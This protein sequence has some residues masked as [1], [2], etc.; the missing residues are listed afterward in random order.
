MPTT[1]TGTAGHDQVKGGFDRIYGLGGDDDLTSEWDG[2]VCLD[3]GDGKAG[4]C[5]E[6]RQ[7]LRGRPA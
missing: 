2:Q 5:S 7:P 6:A 4:S 3:E 1:Y